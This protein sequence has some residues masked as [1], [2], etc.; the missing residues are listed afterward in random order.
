MVRFWQAWDVRLK[1]IDLDQAITVVQELAHDCRNLYQH[2]S[3]AYADG[4]GKYLAWAATAE[5]Q[6]RSVLADP[7]PVQKIYSERYWRIAEGAVLD[8]QS[9]MI[10]AEIAVQVE[11]LDALA[12]L[13][14]NYLLL[15]D[16]PGAIVVLDT[17]VLLHYQRIDYIPWGEVTHESQVRLVIPLLVLDEL[18]DKRY[19]GSTD[20][21]R[22]A[23]S[24]VEPLDELQKEFDQH[25]YATLSDGTTVEYLR[26]APDHRRHTNPD[27]EILEQAEF[28]YH[29]TKQTVLLMT[30]DRG[31]RVRVTARNGL[32][33]RL[34]PGKFSRDQ[35]VARSGR[36]PAPNR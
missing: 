32:E 31:M 22:K 28:L 25:G 33:A 29:V 18:D 15:R 6:L 30:G 3:G 24:A 34:M 26:D 5:K 19:L 2:L 35:E 8:H 27:S 16:R 12:D 21:K 9:Q 1:A 36:L 11:R 23:R 4:R 10:S 17:N 20:I 14:Q 13:L 7:E